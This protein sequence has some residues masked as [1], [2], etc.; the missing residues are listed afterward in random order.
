MIKNKLIA[1]NKIDFTDKVVSS[2]LNKYK[3]SYYKS[4]GCR[5][6]FY[7]YDKQT[8]FLISEELSFNVDD[9]DIEVISF[10]PN[11]NFPKI[12]KIGIANALIQNSGFS[13]EELYLKV[14]NIIKRLQELE[15]I[16][17]S[18]KLDIK[19]TKRIN[20]YLEKMLEEDA[21]IGDY[22]RNLINLHENRDYRKYM[23][24]ATFYLIMAKVVSENTAI[25]KWRLELNPA[26][27]AARFY[28]SLLP[29]NFEFGRSKYAYNLND[30][31]FSEADFLI[32]EIKEPFTDFLRRYAQN[33]QQDSGNS[34]WLDN[35]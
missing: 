24:A 2:F 22:L 33:I 12:T 14:N 19:V 34:V 1:F 18:G 32:G 31:G 8:G 4:L 9:N 10:Y 20:P 30:Y 23:S 27:G 25:N 3:L 26:I 28:Q 7:I 11:L 13:R 21:S 15:V 16:T 35:L 29:F 6:E 5:Y 17:R